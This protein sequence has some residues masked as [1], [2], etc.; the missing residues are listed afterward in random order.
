MLKT[1]Y[2]QPSDWTGQ[3]TTDSFNVLHGWERLLR[4]QGVTPRAAG[5][6]PSVLEALCDDL[7]SPKV[8]TALHDLSSNKDY[9]GLANS[10]MALGFS[11]NI[12]IDLAGHHRTPSREIGST[13]QG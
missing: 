13:H 1:H 5:F 2:R 8:I 7:N 6:A 9:Q 11:L 4:Y 3:A 12:D 10:L